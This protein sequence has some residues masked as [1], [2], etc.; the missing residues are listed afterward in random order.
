VSHSRLAR[1]VLDVTESPT[2]AIDAHA[3]ALKLAGEHVIGFGAGE[4]DFPTPG[5]IVAAAAEATGHVLYHH[6]TPAPGLPELRAAVARKTERDSG[7]TVEPQQVL[8]C[9]G[10][11]QSLFHAFMSIVDAGDEILLPAPYWVS[12]PEM[13]G[14]A[15]GAVVE[16]PTTVHTGFRVTVDQ[17]DAARTPAT[18]AL[19]FVSPSNPTGAGP[20]P[21]TCGS[22]ATRSTNTSSMAT[23]SSRRSSRSSRSSRIAASSPTASPRPTR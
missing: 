23:M 19:V 16:V 3:K 14:L 4:P 22:L 20:P 6:Y 12:Y 1:R 18:K 5:H 10:G 21:T 7:V 13:I 8:V 11:K 2:L 17:L 9:N 15:G